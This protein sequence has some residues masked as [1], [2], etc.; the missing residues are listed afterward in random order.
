[1]TEVAQAARLEDAIY[2]LDRESPAASARRL[3]DRK[4]VG[5]AAM[6]A[7]SLAAVAFAAPQTTFSVVFC[8]ATAFFIS[9]LVLRVALAIASVRPPNAAPPPLADAELPKATILLPLFRE[10]DAL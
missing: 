2:R 7:A 10:A 4:A 3:F 8:L 5:V 1:M 6:V 9:A